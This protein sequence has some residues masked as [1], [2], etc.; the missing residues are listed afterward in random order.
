MTVYRRNT[1]ISD[2]LIER[3]EKVEA[4]WNWTSALDKNGYGRIWFKDK[5]QTAHTVAYTVFVGSIPSGLHV[6]HTCDNPRCINPEH[7]ILGTH[8][9]N[10]R[11]KAQRKRVHG[12]RNPS[13]KFSD[14]QRHLARTLSGR[15]KDIASFL[16]M[17]AC[18]VCT[19]RKK[20]MRK[21]K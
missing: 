12:N 2:K 1:P 11:D 18:Y 9:D 15:V 3:H 14:E 19:L 10:M 13:A 4:C 17:S 6:R 7:L 8:V 21:F 16:G 5:N 20:E